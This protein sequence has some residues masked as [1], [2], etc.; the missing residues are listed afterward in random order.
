MVG[1]SGILEEEEEQHVHSLIESA[2]KIMEQVASKRAQAAGASPRT[3]ASNHLA[4]N[5]SRFYDHTNLYPDRFRLFITP[6]SSRAAPPMLPPS[7]SSFPVSATPAVASLLP[8]NMESTSPQMQHL[9]QETTEEAVFKSPDHDSILSESA[10]GADG[11]VSRARSRT[12]RSGEIPMISETGN[13]HFSGEGD[14]A[15][16]CSDADGPGSGRLTRTDAIHVHLASDVH[17]T[18]IVRGT[19]AITSAS[20]LRRLVDDGV[21]ESCDG[22]ILLIGDRIGAVDASEFV[23][24]QSQV[25]LRSE[26]MAETDKLSGL[27]SRCHALAK[28]YLVGT[29]STAKDLPNLLGAMAPFEPSEDV[30]AHT[31]G[32]ATASAASMLQVEPQRFSNLVD[33]APGP[34]PSSLYLPRS[35][36][37]SSIRSFIPLVQQQPLVAPYFNGIFQLF[38]VSLSSVC[39]ADI[40]P[41]QLE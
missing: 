10:V 38:T 2:K 41:P 14:S 9:T 24:H 37:V 6:R 4:L 20:P 7:A 12:L 5:S 26:T 32:V 18:T 28:H 23:T 17:P 29:S 34:I 15:P 31:Q 40:Q 3:P 27:R 11:V 35:N 1:V 33:A 30:A 8:D 16:D 21:L 39:N 19:S 25:P 13:V 36:L 22:S